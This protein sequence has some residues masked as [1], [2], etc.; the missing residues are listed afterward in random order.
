MLLK[1]TAFSN[2]HV[3]GLTVCNLEQTRKPCFSH[4]SKSQFSF[5]GWTTNYWACFH[6]LSTQSPL[7]LDLNCSRSEVFPVG[8]G[9]VHC[10]EV[11]SSFT[12]SMSSFSL[13]SLLVML[14]VSLNRKRPWQVGNNTFFQTAVCPKNRIERMRTRGFKIRCFFL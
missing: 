7:L 14:E 6:F 5:T 11:F 2:I 3:W 9:Q 12:A 4:K 1:Y 10:Y 8:K 13:C